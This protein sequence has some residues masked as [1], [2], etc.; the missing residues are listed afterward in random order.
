MQPKTLEEALAIIADLQTKVKTVIDEKKEV[1]KMFDEK[2]L[3]GMTETERK[4]A[5]TLEAERIERAKEK[6]AFDDFK[7]GLETEKTERTK[8]ML[9]ERITK[10]A[11][12]DKDFE[13]KLRANIDLLDKMPRATDTE[14]DA[15][16]DSAYKLTGQKE[17][18]PLNDGGHA[19]GTPANDSKETFSTTAEG[20][21]LA[22]KLGLIVEPAKD[23][24]GG[25][26]GGNQ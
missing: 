20:K 25:N 26:G 23:N 6:Q 18:N 24:G 21:G 16:V 13:A 7:K 5:E 19:S 1:L 17:P 10:V 11:K 2:T 14:L 9:D 12:G 4:L 8:K 15:I 22:G 3:E